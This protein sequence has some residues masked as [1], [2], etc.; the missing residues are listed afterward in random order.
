METQ[1]D[2][3]LVVPIRDCT[4]GY[5]VVYAGD[6]VTWSRRGQRR[7][8][9]DPNQCPRIDSSGMGIPMTVKRRTKK[10]A[11]S[12]SEQAAEGTAATTTSGKSRKKKSDSLMSANAIADPAE[13]GVVVVPRRRSVSRGEAVKTTA[14]KGRSNGKKRAAK[15][16]ESSES[17]SDDDGVVSRDGGR[18]SDSG[19][20]MQLF[21]FILTTYKPRLCTLDPEEDADEATDIEA[22][23]RSDWVTK[24]TKF[25]VGDLGSSATFLGRKFTFT[26]NCFD[27]SLPSPYISM[28]QMTAFRTGKIVAV[29]FHK[30]DPSTLCFK[31][32][33]CD[34]LRRPPCSGSPDWFYMPCQNF[35]SADV[36]VL[37]IALLP[38]F[39]QE[40]ALAGHALVNRRVVKYFSLYKKWFEGHVF[41][42]SEG[43]EA[44]YLVLYNDGDKEEMSV[45]E[46]VKCLRADKLK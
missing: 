7:D 45:T 25:L 4:D 42:Y 8:K 40:V 6:S 10:A 27:R 20:G 11:T 14:P 15:A 9:N 2:P 37:C 5:E 26:S 17:D 41:S 35:M 29:V 38:V 46:V 44:P 34:T 30:N 36:S 23:T 31:F 16:L 22:D 12:N 28:S 39:G 13:V 3:S 18:M 32:F 24:Y 19:D 21:H 33:D 1:F 43:R